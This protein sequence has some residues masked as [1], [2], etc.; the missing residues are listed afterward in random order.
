MLKRALYSVGLIAVLLGLNWFISNQIDSYYISI[1]L[2]AGIYV[3]LAVSLNLV[4][5]F[6][7]QF[8]LGQAGFYGIGAY[9]AA[10]LTTYGQITIFR[11][12]FNDDG[13]T[14]WWLGSVLLLIAML[15]GG[16]FAA[17]AGV[18]VGL[19]SLKLRGDYLAIV[20]LGFNQIIIVVL[21]N[22]DKLGA[23]RG[24]STI[25]PDGLNPISIPPLSNFFW[26]YLAAAVV[27]IVSI[28]I[29]YSV[30][31]LAFMAIREDEVAA[32]AMGIPTTK[33]KI[34]AFVMS[35]FFAGVAGALFAHTECL[36]TPSEFNFITS[37]NIVVMVVLGGL[38]SVSGT[39]IGA[40]LLTILPELLRG[41]FAQYRL[42]VYAALLILLML[43]RPKGIF[44]HEEMSVEWFKGQIA[45]LKRLSN[46]LAGMAKRRE[47]K[48][49]S[50]LKDDTGG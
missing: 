50:D 23:S 19:P 10:A 47:N 27:I 4:N 15:F 41:G 13:S 26:V 45:G 8:S 32:E 48:M 14:S 28:N 22:I 2:H 31:G 6:T 25:Y 36:I 9:A 43:V 5:G 11:H 33:Y 12:W 39:A 46:R 16:L 3:I 30:H 17:I 49:G 21:N 44:G 42:V 7:G 34:T 18:I 37:V 35:A 20:T 1:I 29:R 40:I 38:G 24:F